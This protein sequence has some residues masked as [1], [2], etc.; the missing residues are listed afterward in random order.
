MHFTITYC[1]VTSLRRRF[2]QNM[3]DCTYTIMALIPTVGTRILE[4]MDVE[5]ISL[6]LQSRAK[7]PTG[8]GTKSQLQHLE[9]PSPSHGASETVL[10]SS[11]LSNVSSSQ[12]PVSAEDQRASEGYS[13][14]PSATS[15]SGLV[16]LSASVSD[17][18]AHMDQSTTS[19]QTA[20]QSVT[21]DLSDS[22]L[23]TTSNSNAPPIIK[24]DVH[25]PT[26]QR[27]EQVINEATLSALSASVAS[28]M[29]SVS[30]F[31]SMT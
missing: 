6:E 15:S 22:A 12:E 1:A 24:V 11:N 17:V 28:G 18:S 30:S 4:E 31:Y 14:A 20:S 16:D 19:W 25:S 21:G 10:S 13:H 29:V 8:Q 23:P 2:Q 7:K 26:A 27:G 9:R 3:E 5:R